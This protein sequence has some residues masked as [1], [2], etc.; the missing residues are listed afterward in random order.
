MPLDKRCSKE[1]LRAN[2]AELVKAGKPQDQ[3]VAI[4]MDM[5]RRTCGERRVAELMDSERQARSLLQVQRPVDATC[6][7]QAGHP[8]R[9]NQHKQ[10][11]EKPQ[12]LKLEV[13]TQSK[14]R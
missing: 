6:G 11:A 12:V 2:I 8:F 5:M 9:G 4:A 14:E 10:A 1:A 13:V 7:D 3:A